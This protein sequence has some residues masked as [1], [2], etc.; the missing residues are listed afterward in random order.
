[1]A[2]AYPRCPLKQK[3]FCPLLVP[4]KGS[5]KLETILKTTRHSQRLG[6]SQNDKFC[7]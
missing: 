3:R 7:S 6:S 1:M 2:L 4:I 5:S